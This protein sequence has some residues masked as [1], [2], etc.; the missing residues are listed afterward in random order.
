MFLTDSVQNQDLD[1]IPLD[2]LL[3]V[4]EDVLR[5][6]L[7]AEAAE[8]ADRD[9]L[10]IEEQLHELA[11]FR[12][13]LDRE[14]ER[15]QEEVAH[16]QRLIEQG[17]EQQQALNILPAPRVGEG[18]A[19][20]RDPRTAPRSSGISGLIKKIKPLFQAKKSKKP[21]PSN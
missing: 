17:E 20:P 2:Q 21:L 10:E 13:L 19:V 18:A 6:R 16:Y 7:Q 3:L 8:R 14:R 1:D 9:R 15:E 4:E 11:E 5:E 12:R